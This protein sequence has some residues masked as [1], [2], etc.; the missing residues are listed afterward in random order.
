MLSNVKNRRA[1]TDQSVNWRNNLCRCLLLW[2]AATSLLVWLPDRAQAQGQ[3]G[4]TSPATGATLSGDVPIFGTAV[5]DS[6]QRYELYYKLE[7][8][9]DD[10]YIY[11]AT[12]TNSIVDGQLGVWQAG[13][14]APG[15][16]SLRLR[17]VKADGN[18]AE[19]FA[20][21][22]SVNQAPPATP[23]SSEP[24][25]T[26]IPTS[27]FTP[28]PQPTIAVGAVQ[29]PQVEGE[30]AT[31][32]AT[33]APVAAVDVLS[34]TTTLST[35]AGNGTT[36]GDSTTLVDE[37]GGLTRELGEALSFDRLRRQFWNGV[38]YSAILCIGI[39]ALFGGKQL[40][41]WVWSQ[42]R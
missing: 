22:L 14:L 17:V 2:V 37:T 6:F 12:G 29:Q 18:Y 30:Q 31:A 10:A 8:N 19:Y 34:T 41:D 3:P 40:F 27:T 36:G 32:T 21:N 11:F 20:Q 9:R 7:P 25:P 26:P 16:Y 33:P 1:M 24:T 39:L 23:T 35:N 13:G 28:A 4:I 38:R 15:V 42:F 5:I